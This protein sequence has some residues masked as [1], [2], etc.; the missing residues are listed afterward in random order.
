M[1]RSTPGLLLRSYGASMVKLLVPCHLLIPAIL[2]HCCALFVGTHSI[3]AA[4]SYAVLMANCVLPN[5]GGGHH[6]P[7]TPKLVGWQESFTWT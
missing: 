3:P 5:A 1:L 4:K 6:G 2:L 7:S